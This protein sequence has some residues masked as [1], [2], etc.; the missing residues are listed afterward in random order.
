MAASASTTMSDSAYETT[1]NDSAD[2]PV[3]SFK[4]TS[5]KSK[6]RPQYNWLLTNTL[7][8][9]WQLDSFI[10]DGTYKTTRTHFNVRQCNIDKDHVDQRPN[11]DGH[12]M[13]CMYFICT[14]SRCARCNDDPCEFQY[15]VRRCHNENKYFI[16]QAENVVHKNQYL[17][18][19]LSERTYGIHS[20]YEAEITR[21]LDENRSIKPTQ[22]EASLI[23]NRDA[24]KYPIE[25]AMP[26][27]TQI[28]TKK[29]N[30][31]HRVQ[32]ENGANEDL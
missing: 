19:N 4:S 15:Q 28:R 29:Y 1:S 7:N 31:T 8:E 6:P 5:S 27:K 23:R 10:R 14:S 9:Q 3:N 21:M 2:A 26:T 30:Y 16:Y 20:F 17:G 32:N 24:G 13:D 12:E 22:I 18:S 11:T 25:I